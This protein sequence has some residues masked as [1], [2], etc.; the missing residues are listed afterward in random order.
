VLSQGI[1]FSYM[2]GGDINCLHR[3]YDNGWL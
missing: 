2:T 1:G 3:Q